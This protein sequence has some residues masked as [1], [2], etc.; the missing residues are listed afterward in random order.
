M[1]VLAQEENGNAIT[2]PF[3]VHVPG[4]DT[5]QHEQL[6]STAAYFK[7]YLKEINMPIWF[8]AQV[9]FIVF[10][11]LYLMSHNRLRSLKEAGEQ[12]LPQLR[13][14]KLLS[15]TYML[16]WIACLLLMALSFSIG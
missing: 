3:Q 8:F 5:H 6:R 1:N 7:S 12:A 11:V 16:L 14:A 15:S 13:K 9:G 4:A 2:F 10:L